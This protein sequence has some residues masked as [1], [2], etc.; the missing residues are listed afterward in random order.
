[1]SKHTPGLWRVDKARGVVIGAVDTVVANTRASFRN[2]DI[3]A[4]V[5]EQLANARLIAAAPEML[6]L[7]RKTVDRMDLAERLAT[8]ALLARIDGDEEAAK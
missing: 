6:A 8:E 7:L 2:Y 5:A 1:M 3:E 4:H